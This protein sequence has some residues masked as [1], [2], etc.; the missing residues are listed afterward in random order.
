MLRKN[1]LAIANNMGLKL[2]KVAIKYGAPY[3]FPDGLKVKISK[4]MHE[5]DTIIFNHE[6]AELHK[7]GR[8][9]LF[10]LRVQS[11]LLQLM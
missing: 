5:I 1:I 10:T 8:N 4:D 11:T 7:I 9:D 3:G 2:T 6:L